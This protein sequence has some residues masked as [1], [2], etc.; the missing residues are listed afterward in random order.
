MNIDSSGH[1]GDIVG[2]DTMAV[3]ARCPGKGGSS[4]ADSR[5]AGVTWES[6]TESLIR[7][8]QAEGRFSDLPGEGAPLRDVDEA[9]DELWWARRLLEREHVSFLP[10]ALRIR[11]EV[12]QTL[13][14]VMRLDTEIGVR[15]RIAA[16]NERI[17]RSN[18]V[19]FE[20]PPTTVAPL[21]VEKVVARWRSLEQVDRPA[22]PMTASPT[23]IGA[24]AS[25]WKAAVLLGASAGLAVFTAFAWW[26]WGT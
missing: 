17:A 23:I 26:Q 8:A 2:C 4:V 1:G 22:P 16:L 21:D 19:S 9:Y 10:V 11:R 7:Q 18:A 20:G 25:R 24:S 13:G 12:E 3:A 15:A 14:E 5:P 6:W